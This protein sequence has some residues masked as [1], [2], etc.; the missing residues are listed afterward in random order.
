VTLVIDLAI[1]SAA[2]VYGWRFWSLRSAR[3]RA[4][5]GRLAAF[6]TGLLTLWIAV[7]SPV[8]RLDLGHLTG[9]MIQHLLIMTVAAPLLL[10]A[11]PAYLL[12]AG[13]SDEF[14]RRLPSPHPALCWFAGTFVVLFWHVP[15]VFALGM[16]WHS[17]QHTTFLLAGL[18]FWVPVIQPWPSASVWPR[19]SIPLY[20]FLAALPCDGLSAFLA[21]CGRV[22]YSHYG[23]MSPDCPMLSGLSPLEDQQ[24]AAALMWCWVTFAYLVPATLVTIELLSPKRPAVV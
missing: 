12:S 24:R 7:A 10:W 8:A 15:S 20:L 11:E 9:H 18:L 5:P 19:W 13:R 4:C 17:L 1:L 16:R 22:V 14:L 3:G 23:A 6:L 2:A 21:F